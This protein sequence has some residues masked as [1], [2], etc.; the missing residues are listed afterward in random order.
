MEMNS[1]VQLSVHSFL[2]KKLKFKCICILK[3]FQKYNVYDIMIK[4]QDTFIR[5]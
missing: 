4:S 5:I 3:K 1:S 2:N